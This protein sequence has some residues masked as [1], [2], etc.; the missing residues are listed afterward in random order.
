MPATFE[1]MLLSQLCKLFDKD[2]ESG[3]VGPLCVCTVHFFLSGRYSLGSSL[4][5]S[6][7]RERELLPYEP[8]GTI[9]CSLMNDV[10]EYL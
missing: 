1:D 7:V 6:P 10:G 3:G 8:G 2:E 5:S 9:S 4:F